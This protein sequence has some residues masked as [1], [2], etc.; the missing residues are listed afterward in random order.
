MQHEGHSPTTNPDTI[1]TLI[2]QLHE[3]FTWETAG[4]GAA[5]SGDLGFTYGLFETKNNP[6]GTNGNYIRIWKK[7]PTEKWKIIIE[8]MNGN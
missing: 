8:M 5:S 2:S 4:S 7:Q 6:K 1:N 3:S